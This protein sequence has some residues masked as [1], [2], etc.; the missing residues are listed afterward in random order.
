MEHNNAHNHSPNHSSDSRSFFEKYQTFIALIIVGVL[1]AGGIILSRVLP[2]SKGSIIGDDQ[3]GQPQGQTQAQVEKGL[4]DVA[5]SIGLNKKDFAACMDSKRKESLINDDVEVAQKSGVQGTPTFFILKRTFKADGTVGSEK[6]IEVVGA[7]DRD[8]F[9]AAITTGKAPAD[10]PQQAEAEKII[11]NDNDHYMGPKDA[12]VVIVE[13]SDI[14]CPFCKRAK[15]VIDQILK[16]HPEY[17]FV[18][19]HSPI[20]ALHP[21]AAYKAQASECATELGGQDAFW[22]FLD[23]VAK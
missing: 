16:D 23:I 6:Q 7:R 9:L 15:P 17:G 12:Q 22:K 4:V 18:Y 8:T 11:L 3:N 2:A 13:Y 1:I 21:W 5:K 20:V 14:E 19:R 10:Q